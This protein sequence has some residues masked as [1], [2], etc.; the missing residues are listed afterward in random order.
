MDYIYYALNL[1]MVLFI[2]I[3]ITRIYMRIAGYI[4]E[5][6]GFGKFFIYLWKKIRKK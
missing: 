3:A 4:G 6:L 1:L 5:Q 2:F